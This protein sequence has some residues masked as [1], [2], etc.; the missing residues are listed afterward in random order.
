LIY[1]IR[2]ERN[3]NTILVIQ[4]AVDVQTDS[5][6]QATL[7]SSIFKDRTIITIAHRINTILDSDRIVVLDRGNVAEFDSP[8]ALVKQR[9]L[10]YELVR[11]AGLLDNFDENT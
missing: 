3:A 4:A 10:F 11:E 5:L 9:G 7:R 1:L 8:A 2:K 6:L